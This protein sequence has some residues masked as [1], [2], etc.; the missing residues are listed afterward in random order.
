M[1]RDLLLLRSCNLSQPGTQVSC[2]RT[3]PTWGRNGITGW[4]STRT[5]RQ[6]ELCA[7]TRSSL[8]FLLWLVRTRIIGIRIEVRGGRL[9]ALLLGLQHLRRILFFCLLVGILVVCFSGL[10]RFLL[11]SFRLL[12]ATRGGSFSGCGT[13]SWYNLG[14]LLQ[15]GQRRCRCNRLTVVRGASVTIC[16]WTAFAACTFWCPS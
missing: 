15:L 2:H 5:R 6:L 1:N 3:S 8:R 12:L 16:S 4:L 13:P 7:T 11:L 9:L 14:S 10:V